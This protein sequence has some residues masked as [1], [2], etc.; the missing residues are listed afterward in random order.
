[1]EPVTPQAEVRFW[2]SRT[3]A[4][5][6]VIASVALDILG[7]VTLFAGHIIGTF[8][9]LFGAYL[10]AAAVFIFGHERKRLGARE[11]P[12]ASDETTR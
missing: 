11:P 12:V 9:I 8:L 3:V 4:T 6:C 7:A 2:E 1:M 10:S 5:L